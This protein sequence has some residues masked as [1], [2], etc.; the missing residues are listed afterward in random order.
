[1]GV[2]G[3]WGRG[4]ARIET[5][6]LLGE[7]LGGGGS[8]SGRRRQDDDEAPLDWVAVEGIMKRFFWYE[9]FAPLWRECWEVEVGVLR[10]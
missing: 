4:N 10:S 9:H 5:G 6:G 1:M 3:V 8:G 2:R 7:V